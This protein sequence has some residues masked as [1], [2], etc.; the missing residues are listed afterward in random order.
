[1]TEVFNYLRNSD[2]PC[3]IYHSGLEQREKIETLE[4]FRRGTIRIVIATVALGMGLDF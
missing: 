3:F 1:M 4:K 2:M